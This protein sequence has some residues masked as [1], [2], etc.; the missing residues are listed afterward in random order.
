[1][2]VP[3]LR[4]L[5]KAERLAVVPAAQAGVLVVFDIIDSTARKKRNAT[6]WSIHTA[7]VYA[8][9]RRFT[10]DTARIF[11][12]TPSRKLVGDGL[13]AFFP[14]AE[15]HDRDLTEEDAAKVLRK[16]LAFRRSIHADP[17]GI[18][19]GLRLKSVATYLRAVH[20]LGDEFGNRGVDFSFRLEKYGSPESLVVNDAFFD[21]LPQPLSAAL[22][23]GPKHRRRK[24]KGWDEAQSFVELRDV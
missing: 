18:L 14:L 2:P 13:V 3:Y 19:A 7:T 8:A 17:K 23:V 11:K 6:T 10:N 24:M 5:S 15:E 12:T 20:A 22:G 1:M 9:F 4:P 21:A 16:V